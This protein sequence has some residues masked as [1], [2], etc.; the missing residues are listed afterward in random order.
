MTY[1]AD[2]ATCAKMRSELLA[3]IE[4][5]MKTVTPV[6]LDGGLVVVPAAK[7]QRRM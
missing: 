5:K 1:P 4:E 2:A 7:R 3:M 6:E